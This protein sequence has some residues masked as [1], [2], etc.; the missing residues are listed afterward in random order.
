MR[1]IMIAVGVTLIKAFHWVLYIFGGFLIFTGIKMV[2]QQHE[3]VHPE[4]NPVVRL[5][6]R[7]MSV[8]TGYHAEKFF[9]TLDG[10]RFGRRCS[11]CC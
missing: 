8:T 9:V 10:R 4:H 1:A 5:F 7:F 3:E 11:L 2:F 6:T